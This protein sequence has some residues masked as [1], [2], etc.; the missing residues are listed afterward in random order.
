MPRIQNPSVNDMCDYCSNPALYI[1]YNSKKKRCCE[2]VTQ[3]PAIIEKQNKARLTN[4]TPAQRSINAKKASKAAQNVLK[5]KY[6]DP[7][8]S[9]KRSKKISDNIKER[10]GHSGTNNPMCGRK[11]SSATSERMKKAASQRDNANIGKY[12]RTDEHRDILSKAIIER[13]RNGKMTKMC[14]T[15]PERMFESLLIELGV[16]YTKQ[17]LIQHGRIGID[18]FRHCYDFY[19]EGTNVIIEIDGDYWHSLPATKDRDKLCEEIAINKGY[20]V[21]RFLQSELENDIQSIKTIMLD[22][23]E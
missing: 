14:D 9:A 4:T 1:A 7:A 19:I 11:H 12:E 18:R 5:E 2:K 6:N 22:H 23:I 21:L 15:K 13:L 16:S 10:G 17:F 20:I 3:C 8:W